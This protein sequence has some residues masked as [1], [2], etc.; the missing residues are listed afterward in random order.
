VNRF[1][2]LAPLAA[3]LACGSNPSV[4]PSG[5]FSGPTGL[6]I[7]PLPDRDLLFVANQGA[8]ELR[9]IM[10]C[11]S[12]PNAPTTCSSNEDGRALPAPARLFPGSIIGVGQ[13][14]LRLAG[15]RLRDGAGAPHGAVLVAGKDPVLHVVDAA[16]LFAASRDK[17]VTAAP[18]Q[19]VPLP[20]PPVDVVATDVSGSTVTAI[21]A[22]EAPAGGSA[23]LA[24]FTVSLDPN[25]GLAVATATQQCAIGFVPAR[26]ALIPGKQAG[27][28][29][30]LPDGRPAHVY[31]AD[32]TPGG[33]P[34]GTGDGAVEVAVAAIPPVSQGVLSTA[35]PACPVV[36]RL[37]A[38]DP[39]ESPRRARP[40]KSLA[41]SPAFIDANGRTP[42]GRFMLGVTAPDAA[43]CADRGPRTCNPSIVAPAAGLVCAD[44]GLRNC[45]GGRIVILGNDPVAGRSA[46]LVAPGTFPAPTPATPIVPG[47]PMAPL[48]PPAPAREVAFM[49][50][51]ACPPA[52]SDR[53]DLNPPCTAVRLG[54]GTVAVPAIVQREIIGL[55][56][57]EDGSTVFIDVLARRFFNDQRD[58]S[59]PI[60]QVT[61]K[62]PGDQVPTFFVLTP[63][64]MDKTGKAIPGAEA[65]GWGN[66]GVTRS[67]HWRIVWHVTMPGLESLSGNLS[68]AGTGLIPIRLTLPPG[69]DLTPWIASPELRLGPGDF[70][71]V[72]SYSPSATC[73]D[74]AVVPFNLDIPISAVHP[75]GLEL[76]PV[77]PGFDPDP[78]CFASGNVG[79]TF[80]VHT[81]STA[82]GGWM[83]LED[84]DVL[85]RLP[86]GAQFVMTGPR[87]DYPLEYDPQSPPNPPPPPDD[88]V[89]SFF[90]TGPEPTVAGTIVDFSTVDGQFVSSVRDPSTAGIP[91]FAG[92]ILVYDTQRRPDQVIFT[93][94]TGSNSVLQAVPAQFGVPNSNSLLIYY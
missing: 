41:F 16:N 7:A 94:I 72:L 64:G 33:T 75:D 89:L 62:F 70:V 91:G 55:A 52:T 13:R 60:S 84:L 49:G 21:V 9:A 88:F 73:A 11:N 59:S 15:A 50:R 25:R 58:T 68:R 34:G 76:G 26:L 10:L 44:H 31:V 18:P 17:T 32:G 20:E 28:D 39:A 93:A 65:T 86:H 5:D 66:A 4:I 8:N 43:L 36:R 6:A 37:P 56:S 57:T 2:R 29:D 78:A 22:T 82:A 40:L 3:V 35:P 51:D 74:L 1:L 48:H 19:D 24:V 71:R 67:A 47:P 27:Q 85:A 45:G 81:G 46:L 23:A 69:K 14:P 90:F 12:A 79:G 83:V 87:F 42:A 38:S 30:V 61:A 77:H 92:P 54:S 63:P 80:Q 53:L